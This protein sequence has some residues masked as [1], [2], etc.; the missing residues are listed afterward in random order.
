MKPVWTNLR[1]LHFLVPLA[2]APRGQNIDGVRKTCG[3]WKTNASWWCWKCRCHCSDIDCKKIGCS[4]SMSETRFQNENWWWSW[5]FCAQR[6][7][8]AWEFRP[9][10]TMPLQ[11]DPRGSRPLCRA[12]FLLGRGWPTSKRNEKMNKMQIYKYRIINTKKLAVF[13]RRDRFYFAF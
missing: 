12:I 13:W 5:F 2:N 6:R 9:E 3:T 8:A 11:F 1:I 4:C 7:G 10:A